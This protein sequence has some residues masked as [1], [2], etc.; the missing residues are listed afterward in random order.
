MSAGMAA[1]GAFRLVDARTGAVVLE[2]CRDATSPR[3]RLA[4][5]M[6][7][8]GLPAGHGLRIAPAR[9][10]HTHFMRFPLDLVWLDRDGRVTALREAMPPWRMDGRS[11]AAVVEAP[12]GTIRRAGLRV[13]DTLRRE[14][15]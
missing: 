3:D 4:G 1:A 6:F 9:G 11:A 12:A 7:R 13:G 15:A 2:R 10:V 5:L 8:A 14:P